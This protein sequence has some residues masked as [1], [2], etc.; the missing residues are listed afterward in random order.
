[1]QKQ[2][3]LILCM[4]FILGIFA[5][6]YFVF[7]RDLI[8]IFLVINFAFIV[9]GFLR[10][11]SFVKYRNYFLCSF[12]FVIGIFAHHLNGLSS[13]VIDNQSEELIFKLDKKLNSNEKNRRYEVTFL[14]KNQ[15][16]QSVLSVPKNLPELDFLH[17][18]KAKVYLNKVEAP[19][20]DFQFNYAKYLHRKNIFYQAFLPEN[21]QISNR[22]NLTFSEKLKQR[23][24]EVLHNIDNAEISSKSREFLK[25][26]ILADRTEMDAE[27]VDDF[28][29]TGLVHFLAISGSHI[30]II[31]GIFFWIFIKIFP[32]KYRKFAIISSLVFIWFFGIFIGLGSSVLRACIMITAFYMSLLF[33]RKPDLLHSMA[34]AA[35]LI[36]IFDTYQLFDIGF[37]LSFVAVL[38][39]FWL[40]Q[41][42]LNYLPKADNSF[43]RLV[44]N[45]LSMSLSAQIATIPLVL[46]YF[47]Q[48][49]LISIIAN[50][51][52]IPSSEII[53]I[54][55]LLMTV[56]FA[57]KI[58]FSW[59]NVF[60]DGLVS[61]L[62]KTIHWFSV[63]DFAFFK[64]IPMTLS[65][66]LILFSAIYFLRNILLKKEIKSML[67]FG[68]M[69]FTFF[70]V[71][72]G[73]NFYD[74]EKDEVLVVN[75]FKQKV[76]ILKEKDCA[77]FYVDENTD[78]DKI[79]KSV[80]DPYLSSRRV[81]LFEYKRIPKK[82]KTV[83]IN[84]KRFPLN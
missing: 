43:K 1:M 49:S 64:N 60:Y 30:A 25:G 18:Y 69:M 31:F 20:N 38:G 24:L 32:L 3:L 79:R 47:H 19:N 53:I 7:H 12:F 48:F 36:L 80:V 28:N 71:R 51:V 39:I 72:I 76:L 17:Y 81:Q 22:K 67:V 59:L 23:R 2:P 34:L 13:K 10:N 26:I 45:T 11:W 82:S 55:S 65:E 14:E 9:L 35:F 66:V 16:F 37:Q 52:V 77:V 15:S 54:F 74:Y 84:D 70:A 4:A 41:P 5:Q 56:L 50:L 78:C 40:N 21:Y 62:L 61:G 73:L 33:Q 27:T 63:M 29:K 44:F 58:E 6:D 8:L 75:Y 46:F 42:I 57:F 68:F 83:L